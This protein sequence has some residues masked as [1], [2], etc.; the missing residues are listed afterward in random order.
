MLLLT[1]GVL[2]GA[3]LGYAQLLMISHAAPVRRVVVVGGGAAGFFSAIQCGTVLKTL[4][5]VDGSAQGSFAGNTEVS[6]TMNRYNSSNTI[7]LL[8]LSVG[9][10][11]RSQQRSAS[12]GQDIWWRQMQCD[13]RSFQGIQ[14]NR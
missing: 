1:T 3:L 13:A 2:I 8:R 6:L 11:V 12:Q 5:I 10:A 7:M 14:R 9:C 4:A